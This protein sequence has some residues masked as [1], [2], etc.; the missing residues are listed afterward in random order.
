MEIMD[1]WCCGLDMHATT[2]VACLLQQ[3]Q[4]ER[5]TCSPMTEDC[6]RLSAWRVN[7]GCPHGAIA[8]TGGT[9]SRLS[10]CSQ[11]AWT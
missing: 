9:G 3:D 1:E 4:K 5:R 11:A 7:A 8:R 2:V 10:T 6:L